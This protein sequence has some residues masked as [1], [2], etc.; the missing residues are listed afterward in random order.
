MDQVIIS[1]VNKHN[2]DKAVLWIA[3]GQY[4]NEIQ[5]KNSQLEMDCT[6][7]SV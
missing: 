4:L 6:A 3:D 7:R 1:L 2:D 5:V